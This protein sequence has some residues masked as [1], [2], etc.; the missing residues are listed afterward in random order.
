MIIIIRKKYCMD[1]TITIFSN[2]LYELNP[3]LEKNINHTISK[4]SSAVYSS[5]NRHFL[6]EF[7][8]DDFNKK[9]GD[10]DS[11][12]MLTKKSSG[13]NTYYTNGVERRV[14]GFID[15]QKE[16]IKLY[17]QNKKRKFEIN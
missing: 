15:S 5:Y 8:K 13:F 10:K 14:K 3:I 12:H 16:L 17:Q 1:Y 4:F 2:R 6:K 9:Y 11:I 7:K